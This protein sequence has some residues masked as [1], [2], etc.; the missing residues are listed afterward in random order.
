[1]WHEGAIHFWA[2]VTDWTSRPAV[3]TDSFQ[4][5]CIL[6]PRRRGFCT[7]TTPGSGLFIN[8]LPAINLKRLANI[9]EEE[10][11]N[12]SEMWDEIYSRSLNM[13]ESDM[14]VRSQKFL[15]PIFRNTT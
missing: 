12:F 2:A 8:D 11:K 14:I 10:T 5:E 13:L 4:S 3:T 1:M 6:Q 15:R 7:D 9:S